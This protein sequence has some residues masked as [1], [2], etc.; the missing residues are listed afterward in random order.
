MSR[1]A[2]TPPPM[3]VRTRNRCRSLG[4]P[5]LAS[6]SRSA[7]PAAAGS[8]P[9]TRRTYSDGGV[10]RV[11]SANRHR[12]SYPSWASSPPT[13]T[14]PS[15]R[16]AGVPAIGS[17]QRGSASSA[18]TCVSPVRGS[19][20]STSPCCCEPAQHGDQRAALGPAARDQVRVGLPVPV[21]VDPAVVQVEQVQADLRVRP[22]GPG[23]RDGGRR[24]GRLGR[25]VQVPPLQAGLVDPGGEHRAPVRRPPVAPEPA[26]LLRRDV[27]GQPPAHPGV[28]AG[29]QGVGA[30]GLDHPQLAPA[31]TLGR[32]G[33]VRQP[34]P[35]RVRTRV[36][37]RADGG[38]LAPRRRAPDRPGTTARPAR[39]PQPGRPRPTRTSRCRRR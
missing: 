16:C 25:V 1:R 12:A 22:T 32:V 30:V 29:Q 14:R 27:L 24:A 39:T 37:H 20:A 23:V 8:R 6:T 18:C 34:L 5:S 13:S 19:T 9:T 35:G 2:S 4:S 17:T 7:G 10:S 33:H 26:E 38:H 28:L 11:P 31:H 3:V 15:G 21:H 36:E